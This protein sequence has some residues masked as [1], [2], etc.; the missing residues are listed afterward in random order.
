MD[1]QDPDDNP[2]VS[3]K[4]RAKELPAH[5]RYSEA[6]T[7]S[8]RRCECYLG[9]AEDYPSF[10]FCVVFVQSITMSHGWAKRVNMLPTED[11][12]NKYAANK[13]GI[14]LLEF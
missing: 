1:M 11:Q 2:I 10:L 3:F 13:L 7:D 4:R 12:N 14:L 8:C 5:K 6:F 9:L